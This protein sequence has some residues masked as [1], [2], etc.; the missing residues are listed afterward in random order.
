MDYLQIYNQITERGK[1]RELTGYTETHHI[2]PRC[3][4]GSNEKSNLTKL[5]AKEHFICHMLLCEIHPNNV[6]LRFALWNMCNVKKSYQKRYIVPSRTYERIRKEYSKNV[7]G[8]NNPNYGKKRTNETKSKMSKSRIGKFTGENNPFFG[9]SHTKKTKNKLSIS[10]SNHKHSDETKLKMSLSH[11][12]KLWYYNENG[13][14]LRT[15]PDDPRIQNEKWKKGRVNG[16]KLS[17][18]AN[19]A[20]KEKYKYIDPSKPNK[21][22]CKIDDEIFESAVEAAKHFNMP[23]SS[24]RDRLRNK[25]FINWIWLE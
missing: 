25:N 23:D 8:I 21:K 1:T 2:I 17:E 12:N 16:K 22:K 24:V 11:K 20:R 19:L 5:T 9:K 4:D 15:V 14:H 6:K 3:M 18:K 7:T 13:E 10:S